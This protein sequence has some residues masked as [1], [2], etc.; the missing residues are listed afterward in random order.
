MQSG[1]LE[2]AA[3]QRSCSASSSTTECEVQVCSFFSTQS[4]SIEGFCRLASV[5]DSARTCGR[6]P[7]RQ[8]CAAYSRL[9]RWAFAAVN[10]KVFKAGPRGLGQADASDSGSKGRLQLAPSLPQVALPARRAP[11]AAR[12]QLQSRPRATL[13]PERPRCV[14]ALACAAEAH[15]GSRPLSAAAVTATT[16][17]VSCS[18]LKASDAAA[19]INWES[20]GFGVEHTAP[21][22]RPCS[23]VLTCIAPLYRPARCGS[24]L[25]VQTGCKTQ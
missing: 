3:K 11:G 18:E 8:P 24:T 1:L 20:L 16:P 25:A 5:A 7:W 4:L 23:P 12:S 15:N 19:H 14:R 13:A 9:H 2:R 10:F 17:R 6:H 22:R 21:V